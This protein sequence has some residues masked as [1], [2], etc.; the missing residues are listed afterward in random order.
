MYVCLLKC[1]CTHTHS[2]TH[3]THTH[4]LSTHILSTHILTYS[5]TH[6]RIH[7]YTH[8]LIH[9]YAHTCS[10][11]CQTNAIRFCPSS[12][13]KWMMSLYAHTWINWCVLHIHIHTHTHTYTQYAHTHT[14]THT[15]THIAILFPYTVSLTWVYLHIPISATNCQ[16][17]TKGSTH[18][19]RRCCQGNDNTTIYVCMYTRTCMFVCVYMYVLSRSITCRY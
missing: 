15:Y 16:S 1:L 11:S 13:P 10:L 14:Y 6:T 19:I 4:I 5:Y 7:L 8:T 9:S 18:Q 2:Y 12:R 3:P 17:T